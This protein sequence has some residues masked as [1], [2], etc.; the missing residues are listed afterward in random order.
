VGLNL[1]VKE[2]HYDHFHAVEG[3]SFDISWY[4]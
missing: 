1:F 2:G 4:T 3:L